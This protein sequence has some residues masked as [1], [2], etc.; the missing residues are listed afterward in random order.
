MM[1]RLFAAL[2]AL[3][4]LAT[5]GAAHAAPQTILFVGNSFTFGAYSPV[6]RY[7]PDSVTDLNKE[8]IGGVPALFKLFTQESQARL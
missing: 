3:A 8:G 4:A 7:R 5:A 1:R 2:G 6:W